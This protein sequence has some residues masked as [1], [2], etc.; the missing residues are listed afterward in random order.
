MRAIRY[1]FQEAILDLRRAGRSTL[2]SIGTVAVAFLTLGGFL[3]VAS[4]LE[5]VVDRLATGAEMSV[6][7][8][9]DLDE[10]VR[11]QLTSELAAHV[12]VARSEFVSKEQAV[13]RFRSSFPELAEMAEGGTANPFPASIELQ[14]RPEAIASGATEA[15]AA[16]L[17]GRAGVLDVRYEREFVARLL[18]L[19]R[20]IRLTG[21]A[22]A[23]VL[24]VGAAFT[25]AAVVRMSL[26]AR[27]DELEIMRLVGAPFA[28]IR[29]P[30]V[31]EGTVIGGL[32]SLVALVVLYVVYRSFNFQLSQALRELGVVG[33]L[34][35][36]GGTDAALLVLAAVVLGA[37]TGVA[38]AR[39]IH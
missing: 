5:R 8:R 33:E 37:V 11:A 28:Y 16:G 15:L 19:V 38:V 25:V 10:S 13:A 20:G 27:R 26:F 35:F 6:F 7:L 2:M 39:G 34:Q 29:G 18:A 30:S 21:L 12:A 3:M 9:D 36:L 23:G 32:G 24:I 17:R 31:A 1:S 14:L 4:N 22:I